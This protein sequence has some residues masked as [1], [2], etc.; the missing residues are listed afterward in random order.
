MRQRPP[1]GSSPLPVTASPPS[2][3]NLQRR[4]FLFTLGAGGVSAAAVA[5]TALPGTAAAVQSGAAATAE[6]G[7]R[8][9]QHVRD[10]YRT[11]RV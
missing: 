1:S 10:Y 6:S 2:S 9:T 3:A 4:R 7:Y 5:A 11:A 8:E